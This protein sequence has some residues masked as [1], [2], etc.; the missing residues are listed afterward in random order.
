[1]DCGNTT[2]IPGLDAG[3]GDDRTLDYLESMNQIRFPPAFEQTIYISTDGS[4]SNGGL[5][6]ADAYLSWDK[7][8]DHITANPC[9]NNG[10]IEVV[11]GGGQ[12]WVDANSH[13]GLCTGAADD[14]GLGIIG[15]NGSGSASGIDCAEVD[16]IG[17]WIHT[18][19]GQASIIDCTNDTPEGG[20]VFISEQAATGGWVVVEN[21]QVVG[22]P[23][24]AFNV[25]GDGARMFVNG[26]NLS[27]TVTGD[28]N[29]VVTSHAD[30]K[31]IA[32]NVDGITAAPAAAT[33][34]AV[35]IDESEAVLIGA[36]LQAS[37]TRID[38]ACAYV[39]GSASSATPGP[40]L[41]YIRGS[42]GFTTPTPG[43][44]NSAVKIHGSIV[45]DSVM[46]VDL[47]HLALD[48]T[49]QGN[50][51]SCVEVVRNTAGTDVAITNNVFNISCQGAGE[52][53]TV[54]ASTTTGNTLVWN[55]RD[56]MFDNIDNQ[57]IDVRNAA[58]NTGLVA[59]FYNVLADEDDNANP[60]R[61]ASTVYTTFDAFFTGCGTTECPT[62]GGILDIASGP[63]WGSNA[64]LSCAVGEECENMSGPGY[65]LTLVEPIPA[66]VL[67]E[68]VTQ[69]KVNTPDPDT[70]SPWLR[71]NL[72]R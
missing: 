12:T 59:S 61:W 63:P 33:P 2:A 4:D 45:A 58:G 49:G 13:L 69:I 67:G 46:Q 44:H 68:E 62:Q 26:N 55:V 35:V 39:Q 23:V 10:R 47:A 57:I 31:I 48:S 43:T 25:S 65:T 5:S 11:V 34:A 28:N 17:V 71:A 6:M 41:S 37:G 29:Q 9:S 27:S 66:F 52:G 20:A 36:D 32:I 56:S 21:M 8:G 51:S 14:C 38:E 18:D 3:V 16:D 50:Q 7:V 60:V 53:L 54:P 72:G 64:D 19:D 40:G 24:D 70:P 30:A 1:M 15:D 42:C 22:C